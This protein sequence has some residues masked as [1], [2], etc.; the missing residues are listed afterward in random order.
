MIQY[1]RKY[2]SY[3]LAKNIGIFCFL[4]KEMINLTTHEIISTV[5]YCA[6]QTDYNELTHFHP[7]YEIMFITE[8]EMDVYV[9]SKYY[10]AKPGDVLLFSNLELHNLVITKR[11]YK[12][13]IMRL[14]SS[15]VE[16]ALSNVSLIS[17]LKNHSASFKH[18]VSLLPVL[19]DTI[20]IFDN[21]IAESNAKPSIFTNE[22]ISSYIKELLILIYRYSDNKSELQDNNLHTQIYLIQKYIDNNYSLPININTLAAD[23]FMSHSYMTHSFKEHTGFSP[24]Q[25]LT[26]VRLNAA[27]RL[28]TTT[29]DSIIDIALSCGFSD[30]N[31][32][33]KCFKQKFDTTPKNYRKNFSKI[34]EN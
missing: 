26:L 21:L 4:F 17:I 7:Q 13:Y 27:T 6:S 30:I 14:N 31:N 10:H 25:Y 20:R 5:Y 34:S 33:V 8:G 29:N 16:L 12:R 1:T 24:R 15:A 32:F 22:L 19:D 18:C 2:F 9:N 28:L 23:N 11:P 3:F